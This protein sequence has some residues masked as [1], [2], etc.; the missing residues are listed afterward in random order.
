MIELRNAENG[1]LDGTS[2]QG[3][4]DMSYED[5]ICIFGKPHGDDGY[6]VD[7][8]WSFV[9]SF[10][11]PDMTPDDFMEEVEF[12]LYN[13]KD[14]KNYCGSEGLPLSDITDWHIG[15][16]NHKAVEVVH[17]IIANT[18]QWRGKTKPSNS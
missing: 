6:K 17:R 10:W 4:I 18:L 9:A 8:E 11:E 13:W 3:E 16:H 7:A 15:G 2:L 1:E 14:G 12:S 5:M